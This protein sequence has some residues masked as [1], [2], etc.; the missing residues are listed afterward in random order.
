MKA[1]GLEVWNFP[2]LPVRNVFTYLSALCIL[3]SVPKLMHQQQSVLGTGCQS[4]PW[5]SLGC[6][7]FA[8]CIQ[9]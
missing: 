7:R 9:W 6:A 4:H 1:P 2:L 5:Y 3:C 8:A